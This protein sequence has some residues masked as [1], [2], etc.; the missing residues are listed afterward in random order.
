MSDRDTSVKNTTVNPERR[1]FLLA[2]AAALTAG[3]AVASACSAPSNNPDGGNDATD[4]R[5]DA[6]NNVI[7][8]SDL[9]PGQ[10]RSVEVS[11]DVGYILARDGIG[12]YAYSNRCTHENCIVPCPGAN[13]VSVCVCNHGSTF[14]RN[15]DLL[16]PATIRPVPNQPS[17]PHYRV[18]FQGTGPDAIVVVDTNTIETDR[19]ARA[20]PPT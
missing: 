14:D 16:T 3:A 19:R 11:A 12:F 4:D 17:L 15:G 7:R 8:V 5:R 20:V 18:T 13:G 10:C 6:N 2:S 9:A 1:R